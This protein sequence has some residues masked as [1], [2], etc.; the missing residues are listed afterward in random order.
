MNQLIAL[1]HYVF[2]KSRLSELAP[3][4]LVSELGKWIRQRAHQ[5]G[6]GEIFIRLI[7]LDELV[8]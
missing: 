1:V 4:N 3:A 7:R 8:I 6:Y 2:S 5:M